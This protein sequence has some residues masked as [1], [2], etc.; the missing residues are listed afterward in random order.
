MKKSG[1][2]FLFSITLIFI[3]FS[4]GLFFARCS[5]HNIVYLP[6]DND[7]QSNTDSA[8]S[9]LGKLDI[10]LAGVDDLTLLPGIGKVLAQRII[11]YRQENGPFSSIDDLINVSG[12]GANRLTSIS[13]YITVGG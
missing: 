2:L 4:V 11:D 12:I 13:D 8:T 9:V 1:I 6:A 10:N 5:N 3:G 7:T